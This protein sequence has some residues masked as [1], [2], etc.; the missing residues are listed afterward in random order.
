MTWYDS[1]DLPPWTPPGS[2]FGPVWTV[3]YVLMAVAA[4]LV[5]VRA[6]VGWPIGLFVAQLTVNLAWPVV[7]FG[8]HRL[9]ASAALIV[10]LVPLIAACTVAFWRVTPVAGVLLVPYLAWVTY[11]ATI[12]VAIAIRN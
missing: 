5:L 1:L 10:L 12:N 8:A 2:W 9:W 6:G 7:F 3:L 11:A 4:V